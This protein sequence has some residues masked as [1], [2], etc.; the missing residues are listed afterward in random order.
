LDVS[1]GEFAVIL[2]GKDGGIKLR[3]QSQT[4]LTDIFALIDAMPMRR[5]EMRQKRK[6]GE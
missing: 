3:R 1:R 2:M 6:T 5:E 4:K